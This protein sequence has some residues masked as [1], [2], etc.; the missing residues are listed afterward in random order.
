[1]AKFPR[2]GWRGI[3]IDHRLGHRDHQVAESSADGKQVMG[4]S[5][6]TV[7]LAAL[8]LLMAVLMTGWGR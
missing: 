8:L 4:T 7:V 2:T 3:A 1:M 6:R 5:V